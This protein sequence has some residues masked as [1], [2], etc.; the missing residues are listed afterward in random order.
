MAPTEHTQSPQ[1]EVVPIGWV[2]SP[3]IERDAAPKQGV[4]GS[5]DAWCVF[6][7]SV[8]EGLRDLRRGAEI[9]VV[10]WTGLAAT[11]SPYTAR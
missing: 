11:Y 10:T 3:L 9:I 6:D 7:P 8:S 4:E 1:I 2:D 5:P